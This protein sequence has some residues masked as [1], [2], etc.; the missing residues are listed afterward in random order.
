MTLSSICNVVS[1]NSGYWTSDPLLGQQQQRNNK[2]SGGR[3]SWAATTCG[4]SRDAGG[5]VEVSA[6]APVRLEAALTLSLSSRWSSDSNASG[7]CATRAPFS[8]SDTNDSR[9]LSLAYAAPIS[10]NREC[11]IPVRGFCGREISSV[12]SSHSRPATAAHVQLRVRERRHVD[13]ALARIL[14]EHATP[15][16]ALYQLRGVVQLLS[17]WSLF[18]RA[19]SETGGELCCRLVVWGERE[20]CG[21]MRRS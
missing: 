4:S 14:P 11:S 20:K 3:G 6:R 12:R 10:I 8:N 19:S 13:L 15:G 5:P 7:F 2:L 9:P 18:V 1:Q 17:H 16:L 21:G